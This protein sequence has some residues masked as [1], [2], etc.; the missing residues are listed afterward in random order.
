V[1]GLPHAA[2]T[3]ADEGSKAEDKSG[4]FRSTH[5]NAGPLTAVV[6]VPSDSDN[7]S[8]GST[9]AGSNEP[10]ATRPG[11]QQQPGGPVAEGLEAGAA[12]A[13]RLASESAAGDSAAA[14]ACSW[15]VEREGSGAQAAAAAADGAA[16]KH[17]PAVA[18]GPP[19]GGARSR[20]WVQSSGNVWLLQGLADVLGISR[21]SAVA[22]AVTPGDAAE[23]RRPRLSSAAGGLW[24]DE[25]VCGS[26][27]GG[28]WGTSHVPKMAPLTASQR[29]TNEAI[30]QVR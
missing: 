8:P 14:A 19:P 28:K 17:G 25:G 24:S 2:T 18:A 6:T 9:S 22:D 3:S 23:S 30:M 29:L 7:P 12:A 1:G 5:G 15:E 27:C 10:G 20:R 26:M 21:E 13:T 16:A 4:S 11:V